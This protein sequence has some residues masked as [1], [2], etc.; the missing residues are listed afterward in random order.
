MALTSS[1]QWSDLVSPATKILAAL[2]FVWLINH[3]FM[4]NYL[5][6]SL[7][8]LRKPGRF[9]A[10]KLTSEP[11]PTSEHVDVLRRRFHSGVTLLVGILGRLFTSLKVNCHTRGGY[12]WK[13]IHQ[14]QGKLCIDLQLLYARRIRHNN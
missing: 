10:H 7:I 4:K 8:H 14:P 6:E 9:S 5:N 13:I 3:Y 12:S 11:P 1:Y 2:M